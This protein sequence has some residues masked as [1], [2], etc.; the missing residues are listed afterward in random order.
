M[1][2]IWQSSFCCD[3]TFEV[4]VKTVWRRSFWKW[5][6]LTQTSKLFPIKLLKKSTLGTRC[7]LFYA[8]FCY[9]PIFCVR[10][11]FFNLRKKSRDLRC[12]RHQ[13]HYQETTN[14]QFLILSLYFSP[15]KLCWVEITLQINLTYFT[16]H[17]EVDYGMNSW[18]LADNTL[19][20]HFNLHN[21]DLLFIF[22]TPIFH[23]S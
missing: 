9:F 1:E 19:N 14:F 2:G 12:G 4:S 11:R 23:R 13:T 16:E 3:V 18:P 6:D 5:H 21:P 20:N 8:C 17:A 7:Y 22:K 10:I 15:L